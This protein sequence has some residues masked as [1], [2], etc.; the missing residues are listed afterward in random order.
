MS[1]VPKESLMSKAKREN[2]ERDIRSLKE[3][4]KNPIWMK[5]HLKVSELLKMRP[6]S[7]QTIL[8]PAI[9]F[10]NNGLNFVTM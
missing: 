3:L 2:E 8:W 6:G 5:Y 1:L 10:R 4:L 7:S 9:R